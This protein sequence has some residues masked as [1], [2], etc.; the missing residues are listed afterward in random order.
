ML[1]E[2]LFKEHDGA[3]KGILLRKM[4]WTIVP[5]LTKTRTQFAICFGLKKNALVYLLRIE[6]QIQVCQKIQPDAWDKKFHSKYYF[7]K[8]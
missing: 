3:F 6:I 7:F 5:K 1:T 2:N 8:M 4:K